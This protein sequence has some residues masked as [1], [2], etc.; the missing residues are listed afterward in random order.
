MVYIYIYELDT[1]KG[2]QTLSLQKPVFR[3]GERYLH[4]P[5]KQQVGIEHD[6]ESNEQLPRQLAIY[7]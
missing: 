2:I 6:D 3:Q 7:L 5:G 4:L 1:Q